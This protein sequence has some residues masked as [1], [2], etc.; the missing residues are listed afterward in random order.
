MAFQMM[1]TKKPSIKAPSPHYRTTAGPYALLGSVRLASPYAALLPYP[2]TFDKCCVMYCG[3]PS[4]DGGPMYTH[5]RIPPKRNTSV[6]TRAS[7]AQLIDFPDR[8]AGLQKTRKTETLSWPEQPPPGAKTNNKTKP[9]AG[10]WNRKPKTIKMHY[11][12]ADRGSWQRT[13]IIHLKSLYGGWVH[14]EM[15]FKQVFFFLNIKN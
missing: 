10:S 14:W 9:T 7:D 6:A 1:A 11:E 3:S 5:I 12:V 13:P 2:V 4:P 8:R 15:F